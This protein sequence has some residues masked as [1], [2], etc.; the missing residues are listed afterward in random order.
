VVNVQYHGHD[1]LVSVSL[2][3]PGS[4]RLLARV[5]GQQALAPGQVVWVEVTGQGRAWPVEAGTIPA[6]GV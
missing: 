4:E 5:S 2:D 6:E 1:A 3:P